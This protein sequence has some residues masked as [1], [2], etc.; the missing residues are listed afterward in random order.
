MATEQEVRDALEYID[1]ASLTYQEWLNVGMA[2][3]AEGLPCSL[4][5][6]WSRRDPQRYDGGCWKKWETL[7]GSGITVNTLFKMAIDGGYE[8]ITYTNHNAVY[9]CKQTLRRA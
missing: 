1:P 5:D 9:D 7:N 6:S 4:W 2:I 3:K 8:S